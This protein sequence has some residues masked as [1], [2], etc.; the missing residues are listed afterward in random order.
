MRVLFVTLGTR[1]VPSSRI[2]VYQY[3]D[4]LRSEGIDAR[5]LPYA[6]S[7]RYE[8][9]LDSVRRLKRL[10]RIAYYPP[11]LAIEAGWRAGHAFDRLRLLAEIPAADVV[12]LQKAVL[13]RPYR[14]ALRALRK[15]FVFDFDDAI[16]TAKLSDREE[17]RAQSRRRVRAIESLAREAN[18]VVT[19]DSPFLEE[20]AQARARR[21]VVL[22]AAV[23]P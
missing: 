14:I 19:N 23:E 20:Y 4:R 1:S 10:P 13:P 11:R 18:A 17:T 3:V 6:I 21:A 22:P 16:F 8:R 5:V 2:R 12:Y 15:P 7:R 9:F